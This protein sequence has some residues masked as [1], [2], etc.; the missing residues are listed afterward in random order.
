MKSMNIFTSKK[1]SKELIALPPAPIQD[2]NGNIT[3]ELEGKVYSL[4]VNS[5]EERDQ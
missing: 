5:E 2:E 1:E 3:F 4:N